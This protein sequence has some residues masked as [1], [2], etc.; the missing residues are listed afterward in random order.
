MAMLPQRHVQV[1][2]VIRHLLRDMCIQA[3]ARA[4]TVLK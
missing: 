4:G 1:L 3:A 2:H